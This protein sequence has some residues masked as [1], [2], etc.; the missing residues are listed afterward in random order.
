MERI[1]YDP[2][3][4]IDRN[5][6]TV[7]KNKRVLYITNNRCT[8]PKINVETMIKSKKGLVKFFQDY[9]DKRTKNI[10]GITLSTLIC[11]NLLDCFLINKSLIDIE[12]EILKTTSYNNITL[13]SLKKQFQ[14]SILYLNWDSIVIDCEK[15]LI[16]YPFNKIP[17]ILEG[18]NIHR[19]NFEY[20][21]NINS[22][23]KIVAPDTTALDVVNYTLSDKEKYYYKFGSSFAT[24]N[25]LLSFSYPFQC[26]DISCKSDFKT[27]QLEIL[28]NGCEK[29]C[30]LCLENKENYC[31]SL[32]E[33]GHLICMD[34]VFTMRNI[35]KKYECPFCKVRFYQKPF[36]LPLETN[37][38]NSNCVNSKLFIESEYSEQL[39]EY[40]HF[41][42]L[43]KSDFTHKR[44][45]LLN[46]L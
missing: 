46:L 16:N 29:E 12:T 10:V 32:I 38:L 40:Y 1:I 33:C 3:H 11:K 15:E 41:L 34:C 42:K 6:F 20:Q 23:V 9:Y 37:T 30:P 25:T 24:P 44:I 22:E 2:Y 28:N 39:F 17:E 19:I 26:T 8:N 21:S 27:R 13:S 35:Q 7:F 31:F 43:K 5:I 4:L 18:K 14:L 36:I 45:K